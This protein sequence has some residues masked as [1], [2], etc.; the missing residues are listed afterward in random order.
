MSIH[1]ICLSGFIRYFDYRILF[2][3]VLVFLIFSSSFSQGQV[4][5]MDLVPDT[6]I[7]TNGGFYNLDLDSDGIIDYKFTLS[8]TGGNLVDIQTMYDSCFVASYGLEGCNFASKFSLN[9]I[10]GNAA[11]WVYFPYSVNIANYGGISVC[12]HSGVFLGSFDKYIGLKLIKDGITFYGWVRIDVAGDASWFRL[13]DYAYNNGSILAGISVTDI[14]ARNSESQE[15]KVYNYPNE[16]VV[17]LPDDTEFLSAKLIN[18]ISQV[19]T[20]ISVA[21]NHV[22]ISKHNGLNGLY[23]LVLETK[24]SCKAIKLFID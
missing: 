9:D 8:T 13:K 4:I 12:M 3:L 2:K 20:K 14:D 23:L 24:D 6:T 18:P 15:L 11:S 10:I 1:G 16:I 22:R 19:L 5:Y 7:S 21:N 17:A